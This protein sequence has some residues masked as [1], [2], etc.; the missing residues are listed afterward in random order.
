M[1]AQ[2]TTRKDGS[3]IRTYEYN[4]LHFDIREQNK[5]FDFIVHY[6]DQGYGDNETYLSLGAAK[7]AAVKYINFFNVEG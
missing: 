1:K 4:D 6:G 5:S 3:I 2:T 7:S